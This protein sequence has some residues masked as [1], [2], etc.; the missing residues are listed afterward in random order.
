L[1]AH[2]V[3]MRQG[4]VWVGVSAQ[5]VGV[6]GGVNYLGAPAEG[7]LRAADPER[8][9]TLHHPGDSFS[10]DMFAAAGALAR[11][12][13][14][15]GLPDGA[16]IGRVIAIGES[17]SASRLVTYVNAVHP[18][19]PVYDGFLVH[20]R[21]GSG[22]PLTQDPLPE[23]VVPNG[24]VL[25]D[26]LDVPALVF[27]TE[28]DLIALGSVAARQ[29][30]TDRLRLWEVA[31]TAHADVY[32]AALGFDDVGQGVAEARLLDVHTIDGGP[33]GCERPVNAGPAYAVLQAALRALILWVRDGIAPPPAPRLELADARPPVIARDA[34]GN[35]IGGIRTPLVDVPLATLRGDGNGDDPAS[36]CRLFGTTVPFDAETLARR[37]RGPD[38]FVAAFASS[39]DAAVKA[40]HLLP[41]EA[42][43]LRRA[44][45]NV[46]PG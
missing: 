24:T 13:R 23:V 7:G 8:Y 25:R 33:L 3:M 45:T 22:A 4:A 42:A 32:T 35:A 12:P 14:A 30:D 39:A 36:F 40:G 2:N 21:G 43:N 18:V 6:Q 16:T 46:A 44:A 10:Y 29:P 37:Y 34:D 11:D 38:A 41:E 27:Q 31:G 20:S 26:D 9:A 5:A 19:R 17:Q 1:A 15:L 28:T